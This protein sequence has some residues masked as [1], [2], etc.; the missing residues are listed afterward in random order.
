MSNDKYDFEELLELR[1]VESVPSSTSSVHPNLAELIAVG[2]TL[3]DIE[4]I[5]LLPA[6]GYLH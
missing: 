5:E 4:F 6:N 1:Q 2:L 3:T